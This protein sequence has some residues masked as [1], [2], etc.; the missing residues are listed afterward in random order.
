M[1]IYEKLQT[2]R[3]ELQQKNIKKTGR[4]TY[5][6]YD[7]FELADILP[8]INE[9]QQKHKTCSFISSDR[10]IAKL[11]IINSEK[12]DEQIEFTIPMSNLNLKGANEVQNLGG[13]QTY[14]RRYLY[15]N[16]FEIVENDYFDA[17]QCKPEKPTKSKSIKPKDEMENELEVKK[18]TINVLISKYKEVSGKQTK[19]ITDMLS[20]K[21]GKDL[22]EINLNEATYL[23]TYMNDLLNESGE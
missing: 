23:I 11:T 5:A 10:E 4:N 14:N 21:I 19:D 13:V 6:K 20:R 8:H 12:T 17:V 18:K 15:L 22:K 3:V 7:Y 9:L 16:A 1:N 2:M